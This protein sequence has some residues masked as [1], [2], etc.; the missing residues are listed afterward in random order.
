MAEV[1][2]ATMAPIANGVNGHSQAGL[3]IIVVGAGIGGLASAI[4]LRKQGHEVHVWSGK[5]ERM[6][7]TNRLVG[8]RAEQLRHGDGC[9][10]SYCTKCEWLAKE[11]GN[12]C[13]PDRC[14]PHGEGM[15][16]DS[17]RLFILTPSS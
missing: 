11:T 13:R 17:K 10:D 7:C 9:C 4:G 16:L 15:S 6:T 12:T 3:K 8:I 14:E 2:S 1:I 5:N